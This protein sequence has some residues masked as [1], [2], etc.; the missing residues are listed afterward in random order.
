MFCSMKIVRIRSIELT[1]KSSSRPFSSIF[2]HYE[3]KALVAKY[4]ALLLL[5]KSVE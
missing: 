1:L 5:C 4:M 2:I 3:L